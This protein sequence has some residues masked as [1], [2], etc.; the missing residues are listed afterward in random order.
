MFLYW[1]GWNVYYNDVVIALSVS[2][3]FRNMRESVSNRLS[4]CQEAESG[5]EAGWYLE[6][7]GK[8][9]KGIPESRMICGLE[10]L[11]GYSN[12]LSESLEAESGVG[13]GQLL[14]KRGNRL[15]GASK[16]GVICSLEI[17]R[18]YIRK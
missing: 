10:I 8:C 3:G 2:M 18:V 4:E 7:W 6:E 17:P 1:F 14:E 5:I 12:R 16:S 9:S 11:R 13:V 15:R